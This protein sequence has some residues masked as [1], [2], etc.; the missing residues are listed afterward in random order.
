MS[1]IQHKR[2]ATSGTVPHPSELVSGELAINT[3]DVELFA[4]DNGGTVRAIAKPTLPSIRP[5]SGSYCLPIH[6]ADTLTS[7]NTVDNRCYW[8]PFVP[9]YTFTVD[10]VALYVA[11]T[12]TGNQARVTVHGSDADGMPV[13]GALATTGDIAC[14]TTG[15]KTDS[16]SFTF[17]RG[18]QYWIGV[19][20]DGVIRFHALPKTALGFLAITVGSTAT[21]GAYYNSQT[22][23]LGSPEPTSLTAD[24]GNPPATFWRLA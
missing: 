13:T 5:A 7:L 3:A 1:T 19:H 23:A 20:A 14:G 8:Y 15:A 18:F 2:A 16:V 9:L 4:K 22:F 12:T 11:T 24:T 21:V 6:V 10:Q 17:V